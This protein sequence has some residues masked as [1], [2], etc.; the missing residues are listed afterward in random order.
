[1]SARYRVVAP[2]TPGGAP[3]QGPPVT[4][5]E[6]RVIGRSYAIRA[7]LTY[8]DVRIERIN[9]DLYEYAGPCR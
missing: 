9:G 3:R 8:Q 6:A 2:P 7:D 5:R 1:V 4:L